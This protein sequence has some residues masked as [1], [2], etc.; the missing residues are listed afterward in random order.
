M[1]SE[2]GS[3]GNCLL[4]SAAA[5]LPACTSWSAEN[6]SNPLLGCTLASAQGG[7]LRET[8]TVK[9]SSRMPIDLERPCIQHPPSLCT[10]RRPAI[11]AGD[12]KCRQVPGLKE[13]DA[14]KLLRTVWIPQLRPGSGI[15]TYARV[16]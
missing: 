4:V 12:H 16:A 11:S 15:A 2:S 14:A 13:L 8:I 9:A 3:T 5:C 7:R 10:V 6:R 1:G